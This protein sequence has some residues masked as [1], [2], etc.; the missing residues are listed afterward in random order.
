MFKGVRKAVR[1][2]AHGVW[3]Q[4][5]ESSAIMTGTPVELDW[6]DTGDNFAPSPVVRESYIHADYEVRETRTI[7]ETGRA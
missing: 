4:E 3:T 1:S 2:L 7:H 6:R 5:I